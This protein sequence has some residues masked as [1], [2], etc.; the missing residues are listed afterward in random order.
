VEES[1]ECDTNFRQHSLGNVAAMMQNVAMQMQHVRTECIR[2]YET[3]V[4]AG[5][6]HVAQ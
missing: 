4:E 1:Q 6:V 5:W 3:K 2:T